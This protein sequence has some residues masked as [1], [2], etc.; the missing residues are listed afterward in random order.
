MAANNDVQCKHI[1]LSLFAGIEWYSSEAPEFGG[2]YRLYSRSRESARSA[3]ASMQLSHSAV[4]ATL[5]ILPNAT[6]VLDAM[7]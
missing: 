6:N 4:S 5:P 2:K 1:M 3:F 7:R